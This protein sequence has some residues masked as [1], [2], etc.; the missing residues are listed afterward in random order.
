M[1]SN[2]LAAATAIGQAL[3]TG[4]PIPRTN[5]LQRSASFQ[6]ASLQHGTIGASRSSSLM[7]NSTQMQR[8]GSLR[9]YARPL[10]KSNSFSS[11]KGTSIVLPPRAKPKTLK[12]HIP[13]PHGLITIEVPIEEE[14]ESTSSSFSSATGTN[15]IANKQSVPTKKTQ[16]APRLN[17]AKKAFSTSKD[18]NS[19]RSLNSL[20][21]ASRRPIQ[22]EPIQEGV[23]AEFESP[24]ILETKT[25]I[26][27][28]RN[29]EDFQFNLDGIVEGDS[30]PVIEDPS[31]V[32][33]LKKTKAQHERK[34]IQKLQNE[35]EEIDDVLNDNKALAS[36]SIDAYPDAPSTAKSQ[37]SSI[38]ESTLNTEVSELDSNFSTETS[39]AKQG[40]EAE[41]PAT[42]MA[43]QF[44]STIP[45]F[46]VS[47]DNQSSDNVIATI[48]I[49]EQ[50]DIASSLY[51]SDLETT[52]G[53]APEIREPPTPQIEDQQDLKIP[54]RSPKRDFLTPKKSAL[55][56]K[57]SSSSINLTDPNNAAADA[58][59]SLTTAEN[60]RLNA[61]SSVSNSTLSRSRSNSKPNGFSENKQQR[62][63]QSTITKDSNSKP[64]STRPQ[65]IQVQ[66]PQSRAK[67]AS[68]A[69]AVNATLKKNEIPKPIGRSSSF[70]KVRSVDSNAAFKRKSLR[71]PSFGTR[72]TAVPVESNL[73]FY[74]N[75][76]STQQRALV[77]GAASQP[78]YYIE[79]P[80][81]S[82]SHIASPSGNGSSRFKSRFDDSDSEDEASPNNEKVLGTG[83]HN[84]K[85]PISQFTLR[86]ASSNTVMD[87]SPAK[88][89]RTDN[90][91]RGTRFFSEN[92]QLD[93]GHHHT[94]PVVEKEVK[95][96]I[97]FGGKLKKL[98]GKNKE[99]D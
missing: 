72:P 53:P 13:G 83:S 92:T 3:K 37:M 73:G 66:Q 12:K 21:S 23:P 15:P 33:E 22:K 52:R 38:D 76:S 39:K 99:Q 14:S 67:T 1:N 44:R 47:R 6:R 69:A 30:M 82:R 60:T 62:R 78:G 95:K 81:H 65:S 96:K 88:S 63:P 56:Y 77:N 74:K 11:G 70:E 87:Q 48:V 28:P 93:S 79:Q 51:S 18:T 90:Q 29:N 85:K 8:N 49:N 34:L 57:T 9:T 94:T 55:K 46:V 42:S 4:Q 71:D 5:S 36:E 98:F 35:E 97:S 27:L 45:S 68:N 20:T 16:Q 2:A 59:I 40:K 89:I 24:V 10:P 26:D 86:S 64:K 50:G 43:Q 84:L 91:Q 80:Q 41:V 32:A 54:A 75:Q 61:R 31:E 19:S 7:S 17:K 25:D 58:Y